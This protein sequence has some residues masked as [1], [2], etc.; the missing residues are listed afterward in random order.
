[1]CTWCVVEETT[2]PTERTALWNYGLQLPSDWNPDLSTDIPDED[3]DDE[4]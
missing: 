1:M 4:R 2:T 3:D